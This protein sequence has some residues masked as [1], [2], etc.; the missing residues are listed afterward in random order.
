MTVRFHVGCLPNRPIE[1]CLE[2]GRRAE[3]LGYAGIWVADSHSVMRDAYSILSVLAVQTRILQLASGVTLTVTRHPAVLANS[4]AT[5]QELS[6]GRAI[7]GIGVG[8]SAVYNLGLRPEKLAAFEE[9]LSVIRTLLR[10][11]SVE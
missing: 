9:K 10:G 11:E 1:A 3:E 7:C 2:M 5:L 6:K 8:E 4:W